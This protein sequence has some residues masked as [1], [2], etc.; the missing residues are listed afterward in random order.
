MAKLGCTAAAAR[1]KLNAAD[2]FV[3]RVL[4]ETDCQ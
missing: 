4:E 2:G 3:Y 1:K